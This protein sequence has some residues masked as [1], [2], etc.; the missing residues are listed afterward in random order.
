MQTELTLQRQHLQRQH[1]AS[2]DSFACSRANG[3]N[4]CDLHLENGQ[5]RSRTESEQYESINQAQWQLICRLVITDR[6]RDE[7]IWFE[8][9]AILFPE[10]Q[11]PAHP[12]KSKIHP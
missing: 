2:V 3:R 5:T 4:R 6:C 7:N 8:I 10:T 12:C 9:W 1:I 11:A